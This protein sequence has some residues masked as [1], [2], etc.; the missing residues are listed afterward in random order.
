MTKSQCDT[1]KFFLFRTIFTQTKEFKSMKQQV[2]VFGLSFRQLDIFKWAISQYHCLPT[3]NTCQMMLIP[4]NRSIKNFSSRQVSA[5]HHTFLLK[6]TKVAV[7]RCQAH[8][9]RAI[10]QCTV[11]LLAA[12]LVITISQLFQ[13]LLLTRRKLRFVVDHS[14]WFDLTPLPNPNQLSVLCH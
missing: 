3:I 10:L 5:T 13:D 7:N 1:R 14:Q 9:E 4:F 6:P 12:H 8:A 2:E 11:K